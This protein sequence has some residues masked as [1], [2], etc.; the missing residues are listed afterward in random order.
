MA[1]AHNVETDTAYAIA[2]SSAVV[3]DDAELLDIGTRYL[4]RQIARIGGGTTEMARN[5][6]GE[7]VLNFPR[8]YA[9]DRGVPFN[10]VRH[11]KASEGKR[12]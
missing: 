8:E 6:I 12:L 7:R 5:V 4:G 10:Q 9:A 1:E 2:G 11:S 3:E